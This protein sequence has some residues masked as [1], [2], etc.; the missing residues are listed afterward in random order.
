MAKRR[1]K[2]QG[3]S[4]VAWGKPRRIEVAIH[5]DAHPFFRAANATW[6]DRCEGDKPGLAELGGT[7]AWHWMRVAESSS[8]TGGARDV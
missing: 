1:S 6:E 2:H 4:G 3:S 5:W 8:P 7:S